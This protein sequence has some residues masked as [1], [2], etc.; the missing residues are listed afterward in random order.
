MKGKHYLFQLY[1]IFHS[2]TISMLY[3]IFELVK[4]TWEFYDF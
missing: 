1:R 3:N 4:E 2:Y